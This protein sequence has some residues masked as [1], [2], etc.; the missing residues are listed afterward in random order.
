ML[1][2]TR[3]VVVTG[4]V[5]SGVGKGILTS[6]L[7]M[8]IESQG[9]KVTCMKI[10]PY[11]NVDAG[12]MRPT[13]HGEVYVTDD[14]FETD[15]DLGNYERFTHAILNKHNSVTTGQI[16]LSI[17]EDERAGK[18]EGKCVDF[19]PHV[20]LKV[21]DK[22]KL[23]AKESKADFVLVEIGG[24]AGE[25][26]I[27]P[28]LDAI[29]RMKMGGEPLVHVHIGYLPIPSKLGEMKS[30]PLQRSV[31]DLLSCGLK[32]DFIVGR[33]RLPL[34]RE[35]K[36]KIALNCGV[37][38]EHVISAPDIKSIYQVPLNLEAQTM[39]KKMLDLFDLPHKKDTKAF[40]SWRDSL[41]NA[42]RCTKELRIGIVGKYF[43]I[44]DFSLT[45][46]YVSVIESV[47][48][49]CYAEGRKP[50]I[51]WIDSKKYEKDATAVEE[52]R[53]YD[54]VI[55]PG[56]FGKTGIEGKIKAIQYL[57]ENKIPFLGLCYGLQ[58]AVIEFARNI[59]GLKNASSTEFDEK[60]PHDVVHILPEQDKKLKEDDFGGS[61]RL[62][63]YDAKLKKGSI[64]FNQY[65]KEMISERHRHRWEVNNKYVKQLEKEGLVISGKNPQ[66]DLVE[67]IELPKE[68]HPYFVGTQA[69]PEFKSK[70]MKPAPLFHG[71]IK[72]AK[73]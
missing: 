57:R 14:G 68:K 12:T 62:G 31:I 61:M 24:T 51:E 13:E 54:A 32:P 56:G 67:F 40:V 48:H 21:M 66:R 43:D 36:M 8:L 59:C 46:S 11:I 16:Y 2:P 52:L 37:D 23:V 44:G 27:F 47:K 19:I 73:K 28:F 20:P 6:S 34:D 9:Y 60:T 30:K 15:Q 49:A 33:S 18:Y 63:A 10:D 35:R 17:I 69:H 64:V 65:K 7:A 1:M 26:Q 58:L 3:Y 42:L 71:L 45:D 39:I 25:H 4:G 22:I 5:I 41:E 53:H 70:F 55:I 38:M 72:A 50:V 29:R